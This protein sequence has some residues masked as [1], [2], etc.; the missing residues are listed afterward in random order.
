MGGDWRLVGR[1]DELHELIDLVVH[2]RR[3]VVLAGPAGVGKTRLAE[4]C[5]ERCE[6]AGLAVV[7]V[8]VTASSASFPFGPLAAL[9]PAFD[10][11]VI[12]KVDAKADVLRRAVDTLVE[13]A[14]PRRLAMFVDDAH[15]LDPASA[16]LVHQLAAGGAASVLATVRTGESPP[17]PIV[18]LWKDGLADRREISGLP[19]HAVGELVSA[20]LEGPVD[21]GAVA[22]LVE[23]SRGNALFLRELVIG[24]LDTNTLQNDGG[25]WRL[26]GELVP[27]ERLAELVGIRLA[28]LAPDELALLELVAIGEP[29]GASE[30]AALGDLAAAESL[31]RQ[32]IL[33][34][35]SD[36]MRLTVRFAH[37]L[38]G[39]VI[40][41]RLPVIR[42]RALSRALADAVEDM[43]A[44]RRED[45]LRVAT[46][47]LDGGGG[48]PD[49]MLAAASAARWH[50]DFDLAERLVRVAR[51]SGAGFPADLLAAQLASLQGRSHEAEAELAL[52]ADRAPDEEQRAAVAITRIENLAFY[53]GRPDEAIRIAREVEASF[54]DPAS[55]D[56]IQARVAG[57]IFATEGPRKGAA[58]ATPLLER[59]TGRALVWAAQVA[60]FALGR[61]GR[62]DQA[63]EAAETG[64]RAHLMVDQPLDWYPF[65]HLFYRCQ[66]LSWSGRF[67][68]A[69][70]LAKEQYDLAL[71]EHSTE[72]QAWFAWHYV[73]GIGE[74]G[75]VDFSIQHGREAVALFRGLGRPQFMAFCLPYLATAFA[76]GGRTADAIATLA[77]LDELGTRDLFMGT[78]PLQARAWV[79]V[80]QGD[81]PFARQYLRRAADLG[82]ETGDHV[83]RAAALHALAR[84]GMA[85]EVADEL[86]QDA[87]GSASE[88]ILARADHARALARA[89]AEALGAAAAKFEGMTAHLLAAEAAADAATAW[90]KRDDRR[91]LAAAER[92]AR[93]LADRC[94]GAGTPALRGVE[95]RSLLSRAEYDAALLAVAGRS[96]REIAEELCLSVR[97]V[98]GRLQRAYARLGVSSRA[99]LTEAMRSVRPGGD[100]V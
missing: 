25:I 32:R 74:R 76:L 30:L 63:L 22:V 89:D 59:A 94:S 52:L 58:V 41:A 80:A 28:G 1:H 62:L 85:R 38:Y 26:S 48:R 92:Y 7:R 99:E 50:Y 34:S 75:D 15:L 53:R 57:L 77:S 45:L 18:A 16:A 60:A 17:D 24:G 44:R 91:S 13:R 46:W 11:D 47:R 86:A 14:A 2:R 35:Q 90:R 73:S 65:T 68:E 40:R 64:Y 39:E 5:L 23:R 67:A 21:P 100:Q 72:A 42:R 69:D 36:G 79:Q 4:E 27:S 83:G 71:A 95:R 9:L 78:E 96:N 33:L 31:E 12:N 29:L 98:E 49:H 88:L 81:L 61:L 6:R 87:A 82:A 37:P 20:V 51:T 56:Q 43:G 70:A 54:S 10:P 8:S 55:R 93:T 84:L 66:I 97:T 19:A 3:S